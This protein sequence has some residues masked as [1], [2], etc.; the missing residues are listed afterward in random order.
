MSERTQKLIRPNVAFAMT[1]VSRSHGYALAAEGKFPRPVK[2]S[3]G[4][5]SAF[6]LEEI[7]AWI[8]ARIA[9]RDGNEVKKG[10]M[11]SA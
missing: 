9:E 3:A 8:D 4:R 11:K 2:L 5:A 7:E 1:G 10:R 6:V